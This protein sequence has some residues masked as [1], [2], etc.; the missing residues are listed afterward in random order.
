MDLLDNPTSHLPHV[1]VGD[2]KFLTNASHAVSLKGRETH[3]YHTS[4]SN[5]SN[6]FTSDA[7][8]DMDIAPNSSVHI[9]KD[10]VLEMDVVN[11]DAVNA[12]TL[13]PSMFLLD[14][15]DIRVG[16]SLIDQLYPEHIYYE[17]LL[18]NSSEYI[19]SHADVWNID[20]S[21]YDVATALPASG[22]ATFHIPIRSLL[23]M[24]QTFIRALRT[25][26]RVECHFRSGSAILDSGSAGAGSSLSMQ[27]CRLRV[28]GWQFEPAVLAGLLERYDR[29]PH[30]SSAVVRRY[31]RISF[32]GA[33]AGVEQEQQLS[34][35]TGSFANMRF[36]VRP[37]S[38]TQENRFANN[39]DLNDFTLLDSSGSP[40]GYNQIPALLARKEWIPNHYPTDLEAKATANARI[41]EYMHSE[42]PLATFKT[43]A[44][45]GVQ[46]YNGLYN[47]RINPKSTG[48]YEVYAI[49]YAYINSVQQQG[50]LVVRW[51]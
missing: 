18:S 14:R 19:Q 15:I 34:N 20:A 7:Q 16:S 38:A 37:L 27:N 1:R 3:N 32:T 48:N 10:M 31:S 30:V 40:V 29:E 12:L 17:E 4:Q 44:K 9:I 46:K 11:T 25:K 21:T 47:L 39:I 45:L 6:L 28:A 23:T 41:F 2:N 51:L 5:L 26:I 35:F 13:L 42:N 50:S 33:T 36:F 43:G 49:G 8:I 22:T 24:S